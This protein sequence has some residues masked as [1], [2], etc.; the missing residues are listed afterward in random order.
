MFM[1]AFHYKIM[2]FDVKTTFLHA[3]VPYSI[4]VKQIPGY[5]EE[6]PKTVLKLLVALY[7]LKQSAYEWYKLLSK[8]FSSL[9]LLCCE[10]NH[11]IFVEQWQTPPHPSISLPPS[12]LPLTLIIP[13]HIDDDLAISNSLSL[14]KW[15]V[16]K[17]SKKIKF[18]CLRVGHTTSAVHLWVGTGNLL[19]ISAGF[20][21]MAS[22]SNYSHRLS[23]IWVTIS[24]FCEYLHLICYNSYLTAVACYDTL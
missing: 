24:K 7:E 5:P 20:A 18:V 16:M 8:M 9:G 15:F 21:F 19:K 4:Y 2:S 23:Q 6:N 1:N 11:T 10:A 22:G 13:I 12:G 3:Q 17:M 14:Y